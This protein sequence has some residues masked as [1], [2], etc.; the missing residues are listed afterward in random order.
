MGREIPIMYSRLMLHAIFNDH[1]TQTRRR[2]KL[3]DGAHSFSVKDGDRP[4]LSFNGRVV[5]SPYEV[6]DTLWVKETWRPFT[7]NLDCA[8]YEA[9]SCHRQPYTYA[10]GFLDDWRE[11][12]PWRSPLFMPRAAARLLLK[13]TNVRAER[14]QDITAED[15]SKEGI[16]VETS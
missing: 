5:K 14:L 11:Y 7:Q 8:C 9:C 10:A 4:V 6:G 3:P 15:A 1:K 16:Q 13:V 2:I 12:G